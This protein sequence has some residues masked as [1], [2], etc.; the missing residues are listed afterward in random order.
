M[1]YKISNATNLEVAVLQSVPDVVDYFKRKGGRAT[2]LLGTVEL[3]LFSDILENAAAPL[4]LTF[5]FRGITYSVELSE[6][7]KGLYNK[8]VISRTD[9]TPIDANDEYF[10]LKLR[11]AGDVE[12]LEASRAAILAYA[13][14]IG[15]V[16]PDLAADLNKRYG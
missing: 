2:R 13:N 7:P 6:T 10:V 3:T 11:G 1:I 5:K 8:Y 4:V 12:H 9:G 14:V 15:L 16:H